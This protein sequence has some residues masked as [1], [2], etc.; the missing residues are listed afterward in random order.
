MTIKL[1]D[2]LRNAESEALGNVWKAT[3]A[4][5]EF[6]PLPAGD[7]IA[8]IVA[9]KFVKSRSHSTPGYQLTF[10]ILEGVY[11]GRK[12]FRDIWL[13][14]AAMP[15]AKR[16]LGKLGITELE[17]LDNPLPPGIRCSV[18]LSLRTEDDGRSFNRVRQF[19]VVGID[20]PIQDE[21]HPD[22]FEQ[23]EKGSND[24]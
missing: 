1:A 24:S 13:T 21:F 20:E 17:Q 3:E 4:A 14:P 23:T 10:Q 16:D 19:S 8:R 9:G 11:T 22:V 5:G 2:I 7:Y 12:F 15:M 18:K 6:E